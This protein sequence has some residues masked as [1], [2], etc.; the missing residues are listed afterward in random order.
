MMVPLELH[1][2]HLFWTTH[3]GRTALAQLPEVMQFRMQVSIRTSFGSSARCKAQFQAHRAA[4][5][6]WQRTS[7]KAQSKLADWVPM[8]TKRPSSRQWCQK[9][10]AT[11]SLDHGR[12]LALNQGFYVVWF[13]LKPCWFSSHCVT[14]DRKARR[15]LFQ[16]HRRHLPQQSQR[17]LHDRQTQSILARENPSTKNWS[18]IWKYGTHPSCTMLQGCPPPVISW[19]INHSKYYIYHKP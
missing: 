11:H 10:K 15:V 18:K 2:V 14:L 4:A 12:W 1:C 9:D 17:R 8:G 6:P 5:A 13:S 16:L 19:V 7:A 3:R